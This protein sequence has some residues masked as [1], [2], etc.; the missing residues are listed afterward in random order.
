MKRAF[1]T[2]LVLALVACGAPDRPPAPEANVIG[3]PLEQ[4]LDKAR[5]VEDLGGE[6]KDGLDEAVD[7]AN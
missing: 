1:L 3:T 2:A 7:D 6:R 4:S 5:S